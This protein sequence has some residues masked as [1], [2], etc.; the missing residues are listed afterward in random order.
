MDVKKTWNFRVRGE[1]EYEEI[2]KILND[3]NIKI[4]VITESKK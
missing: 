4:S 2:D 3:N 1:K